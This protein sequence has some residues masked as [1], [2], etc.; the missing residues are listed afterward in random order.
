MSTY[1]NIKMGETFVIYGNPFSR[2][3][4]RKNMKQVICV[5]YH[6][7]VNFIHYMRV[8]SSIKKDS[9]LLL[10]RNNSKMDY[11]SYSNMSNYPNNL[12]FNFT[13]M[14]M[15]QIG[16]NENTIDINANQ[17]K[18]LITQKKIYVISKSKSDSFKLKTKFS[19]N[20]GKGS[21]KGGNSNN[22]TNTI[23]V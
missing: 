10:G 13:Q 15:N 20:S 1:S 5:P 22:Q 23:V 17:I 14:H 9:F 6:K 3:S 19:L 18:N 21:D 2:G 8:N 4:C 12:C 16:T 7:R 11:Y